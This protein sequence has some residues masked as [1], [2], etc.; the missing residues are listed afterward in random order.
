MSFYSTLSLV[1]NRVDR[2]PTEEQVFTLIDEAD[3]RDPHSGYL[4]RDLYAVFDDPEARVENPRFFAPADFGLWDHI[5]VIW[6]D[7]VYEG[8]GFS[9]TISG[10]GYFFPWELSDVRDRFLALPKLVRFRQLVNE[11][12]GGGFTFPDR[13]EHPLHER[14]L[15]D[16]NG[17]V[18]FGGES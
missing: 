9:V 16:P 15:S 11:R 12:F 3:L 14:L 8:P 6:W 17:W 13:L 2:E 10:N 7:G 1:A 5:Q 4:A 18:W